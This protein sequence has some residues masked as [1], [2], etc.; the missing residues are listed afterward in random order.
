MARKKEY[1]VE[2]E[3]QVTREKMNYI[4]SQYPGKNMQEL[5]DMAVDCLFKREAENIQRNIARL[6]GETSV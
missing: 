5:L 3:N 2:I 1:K 4:A 6:M